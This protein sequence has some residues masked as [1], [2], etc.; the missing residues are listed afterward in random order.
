MIV[1]FEDGHV[2][3]GFDAIKAHCEAAGLDWQYCR[4][5]SI[6]G[7]S[8]AK[9]RRAVRLPDDWRARL[10]AIFGADAVIEFAKE[11]AETPGNRR[12]AH[13]LDTA[14]AHALNAAA[15]ALCLVRGR[16]QLRRRVDESP[17]EGQ[18]QGHRRLAVR[19]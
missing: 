4:R 13:A 6:K 2:A 11:T 1:T 10:D 12:H 9:E 18:S 17:D 7:L 14:W 3:S 15:A 16:T 5:R 19:G 8:R